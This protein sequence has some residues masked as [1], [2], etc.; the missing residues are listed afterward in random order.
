[1]QHDP[2]RENKSESGKRREIIRAFW[3]A[4]R[5]R[6]AAGYTLPSSWT[7]ARHDFWRLNSGKD[8]LV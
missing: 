4:E 3:R 1:M 6:P 7:C 8:V 2:K 5:H